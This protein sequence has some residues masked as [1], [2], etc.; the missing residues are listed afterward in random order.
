MPVLMLHVRAIHC[1]QSCCVRFQAQRKDLENFW[2]LSD[3]TV[4]PS[5]DAAPRVD[6]QMILGQGKCAYRRVVT[7][8]MWLRWCAA[9]VRAA[10]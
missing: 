4:A 10:L 8:L 9:A 5:A 2:M 6:L 1:G 7:D 3:F